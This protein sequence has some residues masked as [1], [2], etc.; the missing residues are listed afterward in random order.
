MGGCSPA[1]QRT[2]PHVCISTAP[3]DIQGRPWD[4]GG[5]AMGKVKSLPPPRG[6]LSVKKGGEKGG[7]GGGGAGHG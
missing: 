4:G 5:A 6:I 3:L 2:F 7:G 1:L